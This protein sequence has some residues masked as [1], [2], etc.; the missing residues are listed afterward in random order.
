MT[1]KFAKRVPKNIAARTKENIELYNM[2]LDEAFEEAARAL[3][4]PGTELYSAWY[5]NDFRA[6]IPQAYEPKYLD[7]TKYPLTY[8]EA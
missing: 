8:T 1:I 7:F 5:N 4:K 2:A 6:F 3:A